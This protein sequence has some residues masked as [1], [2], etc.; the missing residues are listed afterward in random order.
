MQMN[1]VVLARYVSKKPDVRYLPSC[2]PV[3]NIRVG[4]SVRYPDGRRGS[5]EQTNWRR[6][7]FFRALAEVALS[8]REITYTSVAGSS[9][10]SSPR[11]TAASRGRR[12]EN[13]VSQCHEIASVRSANK[14]DSVTGKNPANGSPF[15]GA[16]VEND[17]PVAG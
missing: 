5:T 4:E 14:A 6:L 12:N 9:N 2:T 10:D 11:A 17:W 1:R 13:V 7:S 15:A 8:R 16:E 3:A